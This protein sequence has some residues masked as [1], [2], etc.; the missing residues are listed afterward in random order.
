[1]QTGQNAMPPMNKGLRLQAILKET[2]EG[3]AD[4]LAVFALLTLGLVESLANGVL[5]ASGAVRAFF[6]ADNCLYVRKQ[7]RDKAA[8]ELMGCGV[9][10]PDL[11]DALPAEEA[12]REF[13]REL[14]AMRALCLELLQ[15]RRS[16]A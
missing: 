15:R 1:M 6:T 16:V 12:Q 13:Q 11:F 2:G 5:S 4:Q 9:Q 3:P 8:D 14:G 7:L 10:L